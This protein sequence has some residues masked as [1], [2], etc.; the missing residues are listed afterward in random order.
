[1]DHHLKTWPSEFT[2]TLFG[3]KSFELRKNDRDFKVGDY[4]FLEEFEPCPNCGGS[5]RIWDV[6]DRCE[7]GCPDPHGKYTGRTVMRQVTHI[8]A[9][10]QFGLPENK[11]IMGLIIV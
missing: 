1:M 8:L 3:N 4:L 10:G 9:G 5:G 2:A 6:G 11:V 7:C